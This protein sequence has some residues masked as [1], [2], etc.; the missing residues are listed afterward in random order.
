MSDYKPVQDA[1][2]AG[3]PPAM[4]CMTCPWDRNCVTPPTMTR[5]DVDAQVA[6]AKAMDE[7]QMAKPGADKMP[8][9]T[10]LTALM[11]GGRDTAAQVCPVFALRLKSSGGRKLADGIR[12]SMQDWDDAS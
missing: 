5:A 4:L 7:Q 11:F 1:L 10:L 2:A 9:G 12:G 6:E 8:V 3:T